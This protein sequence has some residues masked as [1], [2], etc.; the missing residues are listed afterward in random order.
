[1]K[2]FCRENPVERLGYQ[3]DG[4]LDIKKHKWFQVS[5]T[6]NIYRC[7]CHTLHN[8]YIFVSILD[9]FRI[10]KRS[11]GNYDYLIHAIFV[12]TSLNQFPILYL[13]LQFSRTNNI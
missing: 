12:T 5:K 9:Y 2:R 7:F 6:R 8:L 3:K 11:R 1:M 4:V 10:L 13:Y